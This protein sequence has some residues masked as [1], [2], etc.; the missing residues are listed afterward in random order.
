MRDDEEVLKLD[1]ASRVQPSRQDIHH[2]YRQGRGGPERPPQRLIPEAIAAARATAQDTA[3][4][5]FAPS[6]DLSGV[7]SGSIIRAS[8]LDNRVAS[9]S[10][11]RQEKSQS[12]CCGRHRAPLA[13]IAVR[14]SLSRNSS[15]SCLPVKAPEGAY[16]SPTRRS[17]TSLVPRQSDCRANR[18]SRSGEQFN[19]HGMSLPNLTRG[20]G[21]TNQLRANAEC[22]ASDLH[23][24]YT[25]PATCH[26]SGPAAI[27]PGARTSRASN[28]GASGN[29]DCRASPNTLCQRRSVRESHK[30]FSIA[31]GSAETRHRTTGRRS[32]C[33]SKSIAIARPSRYKN[34]LGLQSPCTR[35]TRRFRQLAIS[36]SK[37]RTQFRIQASPCRS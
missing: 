1:I 24:G 36:S 31:N 3:S 16:P 18:E 32:E 12:R 28:Q 23:P 30:T 21:E 11:E 10:A 27:R 25:R 37:W 29:S 20:E 14:G 15:A 17:T 34:I 22:A 19:R 26:P 4:I 6:R 8:I 7:P 5:A 33:T 2:R 35:L 9:R 13:A